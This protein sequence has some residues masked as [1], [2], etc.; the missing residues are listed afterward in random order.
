ML[1]LWLGMALVNISGYQPIAEQTWVSLNPEYYPL[2][3]AP[4]PIFAA[5]H[6][7]QYPPLASRQYKGHWQV[8]F[9]ARLVPPFDLF[10]GQAQLSRAYLARLERI[11]EMA[12]GIAS[13]EPAKPATLN[14]EQR[15]E[16]ATSHVPVLPE[17][18][19][20][21]QY[22]LLLAS[23]LLSDR[24]PHQGQV[25]PQGQPER[26]EST[27][28]RGE[29]SGGICHR[30][31]PGETLWRIAS[32]LAKGEGGDTYSYLLALYETNRQQLGA[33]PVVKTGDAL[34]CPAPQLL[35]RFEALSPAERHQQFNRLDGS[36]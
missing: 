32:T 36:L 31:A 5:W 18:T 30:V 4:P 26:V 19:L 2:R 9:P 14:Q 22:G 13:V 24:M 33:K 27:L 20:P 34:R 1:G 23:P 8:L 25:Q 21:N 11:D 29:E 15:L 28:A 12:Y 16:Q 7:N 35:A 10:E 6:G 3:Q 17:F